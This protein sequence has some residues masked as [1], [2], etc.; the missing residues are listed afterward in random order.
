MQLIQT[1]EAA[2]S[3]LAVAGTSYLFMLILVRYGSYLLA[4]LSASGWIA[5]YM[6]A[7]VL[8]FGRYYHEM[9][10]TGFD[11]FMELVK[12]GDYTPEQVQAVVD[13]WT[14]FKAFFLSYFPSVWV[15]SM[16]IAVY[17]GA[18]ILSRRIPIM[19]V[20]KRLRMPFPLIYLLIA[21]LVMFL[22]PMTKVVGGNVLIALTGLFLIQGV[23]I[24]DFYWGRM[25]RESR[26][27]S[28]ILIFAILL[29][30]YVLGLIVLMGVFDMWFDFRKITK[31]EEIDEGHSDD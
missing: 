25:F 18:M 14:G 27:L 6:S 15:L 21:G 2:D 3:I 9:I 12:E 29:N 4:L 30:S 22:I 28:F 5:A 17:L 7:K 13:F 8:L 31:M 10:S 19:W 24:L 26:V 1:N 11:T 23:A 20:H 16:V